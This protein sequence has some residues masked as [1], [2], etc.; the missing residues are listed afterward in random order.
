MSSISSTIDRMINATTNNEAVIVGTASHQ[1]PFIPSKKWKGPRGGYYFGTSDQ[2]TGY[3]LDQYQQGQSTN[4]KKRNREDDIN[5]NGHASKRK[6][7]FGQDQIQT[8]DKDDNNSGDYDKV[9]KLTPEQLLEEAEK[10]QEEEQRNS[11]S[12]K[13]K[14]LD[15]SKGKSSIQSTVL[16]LE[17]SISKNQLLRVKY[18]SQP[19]KFM[20]S[21]VALYEEIEQWKDLATSIKY[22]EYFVNMGAVGSLKGLLY[23]EN[24]DVVL[25][26]IRL[27]NELLDP[28]LLSSASI[29]D[30]L[31]LVGEQLCMLMV[32][33]L[34][35]GDDDKVE[36]DDGDNS[37]GLDMIIANLTRFNE[38]EDEEL[39]GIDDVLTLVENLL[40]LDQLGVLKLA[41]DREEDD[42]ED[43]KKAASAICSIASHLTKATTFTSYLLMKL[44]EKKLEHWTTTMR[45]H[46]SELL[47]SIM[48]HEDSRSSLS[49]ISIMVPYTS[50]FD[51]DS[52]E[53][54]K[55]KKKKDNA[56]DGMECILQAIAMYRKKD[57]ANE[58][59]CEYLENIFDS[60]A[61]SLFNNENINEFLERQ[62]VEL[63]VRCINERVHS[64]FCA[65]KILFF[66]LSGSSQSYKRASE[67]FVDAGGL[68]SLFPIFMGRKSS[69]PKPA[70]CCD[71]GNID[72]L[73]KY[74]ELQKQNR[75]K[76]ADQG[77]KK[78]SKRMKQVLAANKEWFQTL[79]AHSVQIMYGLTRNLDEASPHDAKS[80]LTSKFIENDCEKCDRLVELC[81]KY[82][83]KMRQA[84]YD[85]FKSDEAEEAEENGIDVD[86]AA[87]N[88]KLKGGGD[89]FHRLG[90]MIAFAAIGSK[91]SHEHI[92]EQLRV[93]NSGIGVI[94]AAIEEFASLIDEN[95]AQQKQLEIYL[96]AI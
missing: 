49:N 6:V 84:E 66:S 23:H 90:A 82:D 46:A 10:R 35:W 18:P 77:P 88:A 20:S 9:A 27:F 13:Q 53:N 73:R 41:K 79:E 70:K 45:L 86:F 69:M 52:G 7:R 12:T 38:S 47:A 42:G 59:E 81:L 15:L 39:K 16:T 3:Y 25:C 80:R 58:E 71:A 51:D 11:S 33:F 28:E 36:K 34:G 93:Q 21:E 74:A 22:Y 17:K 91:R 89:L 62:G 1:V 14:S 75:R 65:M 76:G 78:P 32:A 63:M 48:Q 40:D 85:Y 57:P 92:L 4:G 5:G 2:G 83:A 87:M 26:I 96:S 64:G 60:L 61:A 72:L 19:E 30:D 29:D 54:G 24:I 68:K 8:F 44:G 94:K 55:K 50:M 67:T 31:N 56:L 43:E 95:D 37:N